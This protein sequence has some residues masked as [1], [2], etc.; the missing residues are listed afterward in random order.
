[1]ELFKVKGVVIKKKDFGEADRLITILTD[2]RGKIDLLIKG[3]RKSKKRDINSVELLSLSEYTLYK[4]GEKYILNSVDLIEIFFGVR[5]DIDK[6][7]ISSYLL[8]LVNEIFYTNEM[9]N[10]FFQKFIKAIKFIEENDI[11]KNYIMI[12]RMLSWIIKKEGYQIRIEG[13]KYFDI[14]NSKIIDEVKEKNLLLTESDFKLISYLENKKNISFD[15]LSLKNIIDAV[16]IYE[17]YLNFHLD[18]KLNLK[19]HFIGGEIC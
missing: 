4:K 7:E 17:K 3:I 1:M 14:L 10:E 9:R 2:T 13:F 6:L 11:K 16:L 19:K 18:I 5:Q 12:L 15:E 8:S